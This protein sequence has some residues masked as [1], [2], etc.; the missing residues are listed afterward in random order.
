MA[1][2]VEWRVL[3]AGAALASHR[4]IGWI[5]WDPVG[6][7][8]YAA[9][10]VPDGMGYY[11]ATRGH[12][13]GDAGNGAVTAAFGSIHQDFVAMAL[14]LCRAHT[15]FESTALAR[16]AAVVA[17]LH[18]FVPEICEPLAAMAD[19]FWAAADALDPAGRALFASLRDRT[20]PDDRLLSAWLGVNCIR[21][22]RGDTHWAMV[23][24]DGLS[25]TAAGILDG[26]WRNYADDWLPRSRGAD[27]TLLDSAVAELDERGFVTDGRVNAAGIAHRHDLE[28]RLDDLCSDA[29]RHLGRARTTEFVELMDDA[30]LTLLAR[31][32]ETAGPNWMPAARDRV[33][34]S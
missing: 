30:G 14:D 28:D 27:D 21:E 16:D 15:D 22:W 4:L 9:L 3:T 13:L 2:D 31:I 23:I 12:S 11:V 25:T 26:A 24:A 29:W 32:D 34:P 33:P 10:G 19:E 17:G 8:N 7:A 20:R 18:E 5:F 1:T 6:V